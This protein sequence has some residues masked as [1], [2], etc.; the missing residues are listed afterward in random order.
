MAKQVI[1]ADEDATSRLSPNINE[2]ISDLNET[3]EVLNVFA[4]ASMKELL[5]SILPHQMLVTFGYIRENTSQPNKPNIPISIINYIAIFAFY[6]NYEYKSDFD[7]NGIVY[8]I[9][10]HYGQTQWTNPVKQGLIGIKPSRFSMGNIEDVLT[11]TK[12]DGPCGS[13]DFKNAWLRIDFGAKKKIKPSRYTLRHH[14]IPD[15]YLR[16]WHFEASN[17]G[18]NWNVLRE[19]ENDTNL[20]SPNATHTWTIDVDEYYQMFRIQTTA[21]SSSSGRFWLLPCGG[22]EIYG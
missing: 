4:R 18:T 22:F 9:A 17:D 5:N 1:T 10:T 8:A 7:R 20:N 16:N 11:R 13:S 6:G 2:P 21:Q 19:H 15:N 14:A 12:L 3:S